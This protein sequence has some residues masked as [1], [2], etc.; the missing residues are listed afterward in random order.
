MNYNVV[1]ISAVQQSDSV[2]HIHTSIL[3]QILS[4]IDYH[5]ILVRVPCAYTS[6][7]PWP[8]IPVKNY[9]AENEVMDLRRVTHT[10]KFVLKVEE[11]E[12]KFATL[13]QVSS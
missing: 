10:W 9:Q 12:H 3:F 1:I 11:S 5:R 13:Y 2:L 6:G 4:H 8:T 7:W